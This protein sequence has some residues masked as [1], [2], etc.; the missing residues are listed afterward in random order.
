MFF[1]LSLILLEIRVILNQY[2]TS[3]T[4]EKIKCIFPENKL[5]DVFL[6]PILIS[7]FIM[8]IEHL[9]I[10]RQQQSREREREEL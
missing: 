3:K 7:F 6:S 4:I 8:F 1:I 9:D 10:R 5:C 2:E